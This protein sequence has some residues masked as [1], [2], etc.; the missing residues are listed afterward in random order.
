MT[1]TEFVKRL[2]GT[3]D[4]WIEEELAQILREEIQKEL[5]AGNG[6]AS[7]K[8]IAKMKRTNNETTSTKQ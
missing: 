5:R 3:F 6:Y 2:D 4:D 1:K 8:N 7:L